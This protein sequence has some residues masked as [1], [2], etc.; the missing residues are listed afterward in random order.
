MLLRTATLV[1]GLPVVLAPAWF[2]GGW[3]LALLIA[4]VLLGLW[5]FSHLAEGMGAQPTLT[6]MAATSMLLLL[7]AFWGW[8]RGELII[9][10]GALAILSWLA[11]RA[12]VT[13]LHP[14]RTGA[15][16]A[17]ANGPLLR[18]ALGWALSVL[19]VLY[20]GWTL[21]HA[22]LVRDLPLGRE[23]IVLIAAAIF[24]TDAAAYLV[25]RAAGRR[26]MA[27]IIS[28]NKTWEGA[29]GGL[30]AGIAAGIGLS[31]SFGLPA[32]WWQ[33]AVLGGSIALAAEV[34]DLAESLLKRASGVGASGALLPG[35]GGMLDRLDSIVFGLVVGY[36][37]VTWV[38]S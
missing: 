4:A 3:L 27:P 2:G 19:G 15:Q 11:V 14:S 16:D 9:G 32:A 35:H 18:A 37:F 22:I 34:G 12:L 30:A 8:G 10:A 5:E 36:Y 6:L 1:I 26:R 24:A 20:L 17:P 38:V 29:T 31:A 13:P 28:P 23:W 25:G 21:S 7:N 33:A